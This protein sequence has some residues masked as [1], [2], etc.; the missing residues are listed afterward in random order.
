MLAEW[1]RPG[2]R[3]LKVEFRGLQ[4]ARVYPRVLPN[5]LAGSQQILLGRYLPTGG[6]QTGEVIVRGRQNDKPVELRAPIVLDEAETGNAFLP[7]LWAR[8]H[9]AAL[10]EEKPTEAIR[11]EILALSER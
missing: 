3:D 1:T 8:M 4:T 2:M 11:A 10:L 5:L 6:K 9:L 7:R